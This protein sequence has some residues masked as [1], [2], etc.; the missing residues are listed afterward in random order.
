M[1]T[2]IKAAGSNENESQQELEDESCTRVGEYG[3]IK[4]NSRRLS[5]KIWAD[6]NLMIACSRLPLTESLEEANSMRVTDSA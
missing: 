3:L 6:L 2:N 4:K 5:R 1:N